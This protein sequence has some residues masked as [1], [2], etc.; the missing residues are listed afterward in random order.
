[1]SV[2]AIVLLGCWAVMV[3]VPD[4]CGSCKEQPHTKDIGECTLCKGMTLSGSFQLCMPCSGKLKECERC[5]KPLAGAP[6]GKIDGSRDG[7]YASGPWEYRYTVTL[8]GTRSEGYHGKLL[9]SGGPVAEPADVNDHYAMP[10]GLLYWVG[11]PMTLF[12][13]HGWMPSP[14][15]S[16]P[17]GKLLAEPKPTRMTVLVKVLVANPQGGKP[18]EEA[19]IREGLDGMGVKNPAMGRDWFPLGWEGVVFADTK[20]FGRASVRLRR[21]GADRP[22]VVE[23]R[24]FDRPGTVMELL[25]QEGAT[26]LIKH[27]LSNR[28]QDLDLYLALRVGLV[29]GA[30]QKWM[31]VGAESEGKTVEVR[32][33]EQVILLLPGDK[34][35]GYSWS[36]KSVAGGS[37][38]AGGS[39]EYVPNPNPSGVPGSGGIFEVPLRV[40]GAGKAEVVLEYGRSWQKDQPEEKT[41]RV[42][43]D[44][45]EGSAGGLLEK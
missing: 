13:G 40:A 4:Q 28:M 43:L 26:K 32:G 38:K 17:V 8:K 7:T 3:E 25:R 22:L 12:G 5:R 33:V 10:W 21:S 29:P 31:E 11:Q 14:L 19:W 18:I 35:S 34:A 44:V 9:H 41:F 16:K 45:C 24:N 2:P 30:E 42:T 23:T 39:A 15:P 1:M 20:M 37:V 27:T 6:S 36:V